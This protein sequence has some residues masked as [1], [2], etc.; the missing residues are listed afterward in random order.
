LLASTG[1]APASAPASRWRIGCSTRPWDQQEYRTAFDAIVEAGYRY[2]GL[3]TSKGGPVVSAASTPDQVHRV[4]EDIT[5]RNL[6]VI[7][8]YGGGFPL[9]ES[10]QP[11]IDWLRMLIDRCATVGSESVMLGG[12]GN[13][14]L[15]DAYYKVVAECCDYAAN[16]R[17]MIVL[18][19]HGGLNTDGPQC[20]RAVEKVNH[21]NC[22]LWYDAGNIFYYTD[23]N[24]DPVLDSATV[25]GLVHGWC[26]KDYR[27]PKDVFVNPGDGKVDFQAVF[28]NLRKGGFTSGPLMVETI[29]RG[30]PAELIENARK[31]R[32]FVK[33]LVGDSKDDTTR[34]A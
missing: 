28:A 4:R 17:V 2:I 25:D 3:M 1:S 22:R 20:R 7:T 23:G 21:P 33:R 29:A 8:V 31:A 14:Q 27:H 10:L 19:P 24:L 13:A 11:G 12:T 18:K 9:G 5:K 26:I 30:S 16:K 34:P 32:V 15:Y 6:R